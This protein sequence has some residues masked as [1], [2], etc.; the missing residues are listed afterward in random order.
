METGV[1]TRRDRDSDCIS[2]TSR[3]KEVGG[4]EWERLR[5]KGRGER[6]KHSKKERRRKRVGEGII[7][8]SSVFSLI[9]SPESSCKVFINLLKMTNPPQID[10]SNLTQNDS[11]FHHEKEDRDEMSEFSKL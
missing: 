2:E 6:E 10:I 3:E 5:S 11:S 1:E 9:Q 4:G 8:S 7:W